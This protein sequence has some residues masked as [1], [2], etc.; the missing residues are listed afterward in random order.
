MAAAVVTAPVALLS[1]GQVA[2]S[3]SSQFV[4][5]PVAQLRRR[6]VLRAQAMRRGR[7]RRSW[8]VYAQT[9]AV[10]PAHMHDSDD[11]D[12][13]ALKPSTSAA[14]SRFPNTPTHAPAQLSDRN[15]DALN[16]LIKAMR[17]L[18]LAF[19]LL[20]SVNA[21]RT[22]HGVFVVAA[23]SRAIDWWKLTELLGAV[24]GYTMAVFLFHACKPVSAFVKKHAGLS[25]EE[26]D[27]LRHE[28]FTEVAHFFSKAR[29]VLLPLAVTRLAYFIN[30]LVPFMDTTRS[31]IIQLIMAVFANVTSVA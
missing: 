7:G 11:N 30:D 2:A 12:E 25:W 1:T 4:C 13:E 31:T 17:Q 22:L 14:A 23:K 21:V 15:L 8:H 3:L 26:Q 19:F 24:D 16:A 9:A 10:T 28:A 20:A 6:E 18:G 5:G 29:A 27:N